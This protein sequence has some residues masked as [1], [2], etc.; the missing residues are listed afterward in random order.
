MHSRSNYLIACLIIAIAAF[1]VFAIGLSLPPL[2]GF[3]DDVYVLKNQ[4]RL[5]ISM[6][7]ICFW[8][9]SAYYHN[10]IPLTMFSYMIDS[11]IGGITIGS[12][13]GFVYHLQN[14]FWHIVSACGLLA[15]L[16][17]LEVRPRIALM[18]ALIWTVHPQRVESV[19]WISERKDVLCAAW[20]LWGLVAYIHFR[21]AQK[22]RVALPLLFFILAL[23]SK[24]MA[25]SFPLILVLYEW[26]LGRKV[27][28]R[29]WVLRLWPYILLAA[30]FVPITLLAQGDAVQEH[31][32]IVRRITVVVH[33]VFWYIQKTLVPTGLYPMHPRLTSHSASIRPVV[34]VAVL[35]VVCGY[36]YRGRCTNSG[37]LRDWLPLL[38]AYPIVLAPVAGFFPLGAIDYADRYSYLPSAALLC[39]FAA[40]V[41][42]CRCPRI[43]EHRAFG[44]IIAAGCAVGGIV[45]LIFSTL[46]MMYIPN[47]T[48][49]RHILVTSA[50]HP[51]PNPVAVNDLG[52]VNLAYGYLEEADAQADM[53]LGDDV[54]YQS[55]ERR[56]I[57]QVHA[58]FLK[59]RIAERQS[60][61]AAVL[62]EFEQCKA[63]L[64]RLFGDDT[65]QTAEFL[66]MIGNLYAN[67]E[68]YD[69]AASC[70]ES[71][72]GFMPASP[73]A[74]ALLE[75]LKQRSQK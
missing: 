70:A 22:P 27:D 33:N 26:H 37:S 67:Q 65:T 72:L 41:S 11:A 36:L 24:P 68:R 55:N 58:H 62:R 21:N 28:I 39:L 14:L 17:L 61:T 19:V 53:L 57:G 2:N 59:L 50:A 9:S 49:I 69:D 10:Y 45:I 7:N 8:L 5:A 12:T 48:S 74:Q 23:L 51:Q 42:R 63:F 73:S 38:L 25:I 60:N 40:A 47:W 15:L 18:T 4:S 3:D 52:E 46:S 75:T 64:P 30:V 66:V 31:V 13:N 20:Y 71:A 56:Q 32:P 1:V 29:S 34:I 16:R 43:S 44:S 35:C 6:E 54:A